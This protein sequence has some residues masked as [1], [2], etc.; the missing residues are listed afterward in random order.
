MPPSKKQRGQAARGQPAGGEQLVDAARQGDT[1]GVAR[2]LATGADPNASVPVGWTTSGEVF[3]T[4]VLREAAMNGRLEVLRLLLDGGA[5]PSL[6]S[7][8]GDTPLV[9]AAAYG[10]LEMLRLLLGRGAVVD[11]VNP[12]GTGGTA[13]HSACVLNQAECA[14]EL[15][16]A[17][18][19]VGLRDNNGQ[20]GREVAEAKGHTAVMERLRAL[21]ADQLRAA[22]AAAVAPEPALEPAPASEAEP[23]LEPADAA[24]EELLLAAGRGDAAAAA[25]VGATQTG[26]SRVFLT[27]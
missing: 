22:Q 20:T 8:G 19:N 3:Q 11:A 16:R 12:G 1:T 13:F 18:C 14:E 21:V 5:D 15:A 25:R 27:P 17:G 23:A 2:L 7:S 6:A 24:G 10:H 26:G 4:T 9:I